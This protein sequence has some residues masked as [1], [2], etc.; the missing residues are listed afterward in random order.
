MQFEHRHGVT[1]LDEVLRAQLASAREIA[2]ATPARVPGL[3]RA[4]RACTRIL[5]DSLASPAPGAP[6]LPPGVVQALSSLPLNRGP[7]RE[8][9]LNG[10]FSDGG[11]VA[12]QIRALRNAFAL[13]PGATP[14]GTF[15]T[16]LGLL[17]SIDG[18]PP[19]TC[20]DLDVG[21]KRWTRC[22]ILDP[23]RLPHGLLELWGMPPFPIHL[24]RPT[25]SGAH[26]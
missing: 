16:D 11:L 7:G 19:T 1:D 4:L 14:L 2:A 12:V 8:T 9:Y 20:W 5:A 26:P 21:G 24:V 18:H 25:P 15:L 17:T 10:G 23:A 6:P 13:V 22:L 3:S